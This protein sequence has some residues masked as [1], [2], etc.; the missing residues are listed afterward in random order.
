MENYEIRQLS[1]LADVCLRSAQKWAR[2]EEV[3]GLA[4]ERLARVAR[5][6]GYKRASLPQPEVRRAG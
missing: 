3:K 2:G 5:E 6:H 4:G 1:R